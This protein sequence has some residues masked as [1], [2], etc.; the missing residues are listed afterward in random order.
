MAP[1]VYHR[2]RWNEGGKED[3]V[4]VGHQLFLFR[5]ACLALGMFCAVYVVCD[6]LFGLWAALT[7]SAALAVLVGVT[8]Y[9]LPVERGQDPRVRR[10]E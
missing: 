6:F 1:S 2:I 3:V 4:R 9:I 5:T 10:L 7:A 8:W